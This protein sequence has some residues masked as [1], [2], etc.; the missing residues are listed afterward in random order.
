MYE[1]RFTIDQRIY[2]TPFFQLVPVDALTQKIDKRFDY[3]DGIL[4]LHESGTSQRNN[5]LASSTTADNRMTHGCIVA[6]YE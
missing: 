1:G 4:G 3:D 6:S 2:Y 5:A